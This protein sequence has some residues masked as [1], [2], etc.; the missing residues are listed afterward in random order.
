MSHNIE[1]RDGRWSFAFT[2]ARDQIWH[3]LGQEVAVGASREEWLNASGLNFCVVKIPAIAALEGPEFD[4]IAADRRFLP[5]PN[6]N[7]LVRQDNGHVLGPCSDM[8]QLVQPADVWDWFEQYITADE[9]FHVDAAGVLHS[10]ESIWCTAVFNGGMEVAGENHKARLLMSTS[11]DQSR[12]TT[13]QGTVTRA[14]CNNTLSAAWADNRAV[15]RTSHRSRFS[16]KQVASELATIAQSFETYKA[17]GDAM[18][19]TA[20]AKEEVS[21]FFKEVLEIPFEAKSEDVSARKL[22]QFSDLSRA[23]SVTKRERNSST[24]DVWTALQAVTRYADHDRS[25]R[26]GNGTA[27]DIL[28][29]RFAASTFG[30][31]NDLKGRAV[32]LLMP[33]IKDR[34]PVL[35]A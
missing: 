6:R 11:F 32:Q 1:N 33:R 5:A 4:H 12:P 8:Y 19:Q 35:A 25:V 28:V 24:D 26:S 2:G 21:K 16:G 27:D 30:S 23:Y 7:F 34:V 31:G 13:N 29:S 3:R 18:A 10:G 14:V 15:I 9:R 22:N 20:M 17:M